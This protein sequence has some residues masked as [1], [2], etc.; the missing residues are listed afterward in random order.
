MKA[1]PQLIFGYHGCERDV[2][3]DVV[4]HRDVLRP[5]ENRWDWLGTSRGPSGRVVVVG[6]GAAA[7]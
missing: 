7:L 5:S 6:V 3:E 4:M 2:A 1:F